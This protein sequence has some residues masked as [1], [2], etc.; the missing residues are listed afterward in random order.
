MVSWTT[1]LL[2]PF[3]ILNISRKAK[4]TLQIASASFDSYCQYCLVVR[5][6][7]D[8]DLTTMDSCKDDLLPWSSFKEQQF[9]PTTLTTNEPPASGK[10]TADN[11][12][13]AVMKDCPITYQHDLSNFLVKAWNRPSP[14]SSLNMDLDFRTFR[15]NE[16]QI[17]KREISHLVRSSGSTAS[18]SF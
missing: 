5:R 12:L 7:P 8:L 9:L 4:H 18:E 1:L 2:S 3:S 11:C 17:S 15:E 10:T 6:P 16:S 14:H 13:N